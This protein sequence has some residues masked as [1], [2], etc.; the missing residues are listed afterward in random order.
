MANIKFSQFTSGANADADSRIVGFQNGGTTNNFW[1]PSELANALSSHLSSIYTANGTLAASRTVTMNAFD[2]NFASSTAGQQVSFEQNVKVGGQAYTLLHDI[3]TV[4]TATW[5]INW[6]N[7]NVQAITLNNGGAM[8]LN[9]PTNPETGATYIL[10]LIQGASPSTVTWTSSIFKWASATPP[11]LST[12][13]GQI[14]IITLIY[15]GTNYYGSSV[16]NLS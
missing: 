11:V 13:A 1:T 8:T 2:L 7:S 15:D 12:S 3:G 6:D 9:T 10:K 4:A 14:D 16:L 5:D